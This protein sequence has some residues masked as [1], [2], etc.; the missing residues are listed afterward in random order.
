MACAADNYFEAAGIDGDGYQFYLDATRFL[1]WVFAFDGDVFNKDLNQFLFDGVA[2]SS[3]LTFLNDL[4]VSGCAGIVTDRSTSQAAFSQ[5]SLLFMVDSS[6]HLS[7][8]DEL[9][10]NSSNFNWS[11]APLP[12]TS[13]NPIQNLFGASLSI[14]KSTPEKELAAWLFIKYFT[15]PEIQAK[16][17]EG[18]GYLPVRFGA[19]EHLGDY[20]KKVPEYQI[21]FDL[22]PFGKTEPSLPGYD[23]IHQEIELAL[24]M[25]F[26]SESEEPEQGE[27]SVNLAEILDSLNGTVNQILLIHLD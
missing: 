16:W 5:G 19:N 4:V 25:I 1:S 3:T 6:F 15:E 21:V 18:A 7:T 8:V 11:V 24:Q 9:V 22:L 27:D 12:S 23:F 20:F 17:G 2:T 10:T 14:P 26:L 13:E